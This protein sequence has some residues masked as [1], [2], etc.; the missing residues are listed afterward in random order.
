MQAPE[1]RRSLNTYLRSAKDLARLAAHADRL[2][3]LQQTYAQIAPQ[4]LAEASQVANYKSGKVVIHAASGAVAAK[5]MQL[6]PRLRGEFFKRGCEVTEITVRVQVRARPD[7]APAPRPVREI[8]GT[9]VQ[10]LTWLESS[11][12]ADSPLGSALKRLLDHA[13]HGR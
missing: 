3:A 13:R 7:A 1:Y 5:I 11:L 6:E 2:L 8:S 10:G 12:P 4:Y 9:A